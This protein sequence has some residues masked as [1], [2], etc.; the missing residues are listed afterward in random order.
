MATRGRVAGYQDMNRMNRAQ[1]NTGE[2]PL[3]TQEKALQLC[4]RSQKRGA[5]LSVGFFMTKKGQFCLTLALIV[6]G[7]VMQSP[8]LEACAAGMGAITAA[9]W[10][11]SHSRDGGKSSIAYDERAIN[12]F[13]ND[14][15]AHCGNWGE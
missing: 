5:V 13:E 3:V 6:G 9:H 1:G 11:I 8:S 12:T 2:H 7:T 14:P 15:D 4:Q 10:L